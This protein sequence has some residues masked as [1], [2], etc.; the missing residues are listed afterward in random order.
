M[1]K[2][3]DHW[4]NVCKVHWKEIVTLSIALHWIVDL[5]I[6]GPIAIAIGWFARGYFG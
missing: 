6:I 5:F 3:F 4:K 2:R 1:H